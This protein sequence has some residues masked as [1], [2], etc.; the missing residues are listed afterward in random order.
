MSYLKGRQMEPQEYRNKP[1]AIY[2]NS[3]AGGQDLWRSPI[4][5]RCGVA[6]TVMRS[7]ITSEINIFYLVSWSM[8]FLY[9]LFFLARGE[10]AKMQIIWVANKTQRADRLLCQLLPPESWKNQCS[11]Y[12]ITFLGTAAMSVLWKPWI[13]QNPSG[14]NCDSRCRGV[15]GDVKARTGLRLIKITFSHTVKTLNFKL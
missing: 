11:S 12:S 8:N 15:T 7:V 2:W 4:H 9:P 13:R 3:Q 1:S 10:R 14:A 6:I 5:G